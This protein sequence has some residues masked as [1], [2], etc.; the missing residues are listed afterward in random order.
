MI[1]LVSVLIF[2]MLLSFG[3][4]KKLTLKKDLSSSKDKV[5]SVIT[6][7]INPSIKISLNEEEE[8]INIEALNDDAKEILVNY[9][10][11]KLSTVMEEFVSKLKEKGYTKDKLYIIVGITGKI[12]KERA[13]KL[14]SEDLTKN[15]VSY[16]LIV[17]K[18]TKDAK[19]LAEKYNITESKAS[20]ISKIITEHPE[21]KIEDLKDMNV[22]NIVKK[23]NELSAPVTTTTAS[24]TTTTTKAKT[25]TTTTKA[26][27]TTTKTTKAPSNNS[28]SS[29][30]QRKC[31]NVNYALTNEE[32]AIK[33]ASL[34]GA[35]VKKNYCSILM[36]ESFVT[37]ASDGSC[38]YKV[39]FKYRTESC[40]YYIS[41][42]TGNILS[43]SCVPATLNAGE[44]QCIIMDNLGLTKRE[45][46]YIS[47]ERDLGS[48][49]VSD[50]EDVYGTPNENG[51]NFIYEY[52]VSKTTGKITEKKIIGIVK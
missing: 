1:I 7:D 14:I 12:D 3:I 34:K 16:E 6:L 9:Q 22:N 21:V 26:K 10:N 30:S 18:Q 19:E 33:A 52:H 15:S 44:N 43:S 24:F 49:F 37:L 11:K 13:T 46:L 2:A 25:T 31:D 35:T 47:N 28:Q 29:G 40:V 17:P 41:V 23:E 38:A 51:E 48:E 50:V 36:L 45:M 5:I 39:S 8:V 4:Y 20:Y 27:T 42:E 32:A